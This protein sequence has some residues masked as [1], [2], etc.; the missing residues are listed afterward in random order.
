MSKMSTDPARHALNGPTMGTRW[1]VLFFAERGL[2]PAP[3][4]AALQAAVDAVDAQMSLW[5]PGS[6]LMRLNAAPVGDWQQVPPDLARVLRLGIATPEEPPADA[7]RGDQ[8]DPE[9]EGGACGHGGMLPPWPGAGWEWDPGQRL[10][11]STASR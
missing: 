7:C 5:K 8:G 6:D 1:S 10:A 3:L 2:D 4:Q 11:W 9:Q